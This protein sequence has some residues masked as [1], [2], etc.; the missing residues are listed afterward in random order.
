VTGTLATLVQAGSLLYLGLAR[1]STLDMGLTV[2]LELALAGLLLLTAAAGGRDSSGRRVSAAWCAAAGAGCGAG[3]P[4]E[5]AGRH[6]DSR[7][8]HGHLHAAATRLEPGVARA[9]VVDARGAG[10]TRCPPWLWLVEQ[11]NPGFAQFFFVHEQFARFLTR[12]HQRYEPDWFF[13]PVLLAGFMPWTPLLPAIIR[14]GWRD[15]RAGD[16]GALAAGDLGCLLLPV[17]QPVA[18]EADSVHPAAV[19]GAQPAGGTCADCARAAPGLAWRW[20]SQR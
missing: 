6:I 4:L 8:R 7:R 2:T 1:I 17:L 3:F 15:I 10:S 20:R 11:R 18:I 13:V 16:R 19:P 14:R 5:G 12:V 9:A